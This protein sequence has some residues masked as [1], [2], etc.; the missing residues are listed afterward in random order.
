MGGRASRSAF[1]DRLQSTMPNAPCRSPRLLKQ[2]PRYEGI[3]KPSKK[4]GKKY[5]ASDAKQSSTQDDNQPEN[6]VHAET[7]PETTSFEMQIWNLLSKEGLNRKAAKEKLGLPEHA[8]SYLDFVKLDPDSPLRESRQQPCEYATV[9]ACTW[10]PDKQATYTLYNDRFRTWH[11]LVP[12]TDM[13]LCSSYE[14]DYQLSR[15]AFFRSDFFTC[16]Q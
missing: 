15:I 11:F 14:T 13:T 10:N 12:E 5:K 8:F 9:K 6:E 4:A 3:T 7:S 2:E 16:S 1:R